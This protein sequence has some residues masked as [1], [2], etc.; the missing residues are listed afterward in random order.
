MDKKYY[1][2]L[3][4]CVTVKKSEIHGLGLYAT[5][6]IEKEINLGIS[7][8][9]DDRF[10]NGYSRT[11]LGGFFN[12]SETPN[13]Y[14]V[15]EGDFIYLKSLKE[16]APGD[17]LTV[18]YTFYNPEKSNHPQVLESAHF[19]EIVKKECDAAGVKYLF[20]ETNK[21]DYPGV[22]NI[23]ASGYFDDKIGPTLAC[24]IGKPEKD[25]YEILIHESCHMDQWK[26]KD[27]L[28]LAQ[29]SKGIDCDKG[30]DEW[31]SGKDFHPDEYT[32]CIQTMQSLEIDCEK[33]AV[34]KILDLGL[35]IDTV[36]YIKRANAYLFFYDI[37]LETRKWS[38]VAP[39]DVEE[40]INAM[41]GYFLKDEDY[42]NMPEILKP[43]YKKHCYND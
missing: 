40:I 2:P 31:L 41:P 6:A 21:V 10:E 27:P 15:Y 4:D 5:K 33:R 36:R 7:H 35:G 14:V 39:Y 12:H 22:G 1:M 38:D 18:T 29:Y 30:M 34:R 43:L 11:P 17:E 42:R 13:C 16:L 20:P 24:A 25:W 9:K 26:E 23:Q 8:I 3:P 37:I 19:L 32:Y 28:W